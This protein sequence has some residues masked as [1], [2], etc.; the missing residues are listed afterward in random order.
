MSAEE[1]EK[2]PGEGG[3]QPPGLSRDELLKFFDL[4]AELSTT[5][6]DPL[7]HAAPPTPRRADNPDAMVTDDWG[8]RRGR[9]L[10]EEHPE[11]E[12][13]GLD[14][15][16]LADFHAACFDVEPEL[17]PDCA[18]LLKH[19]FLSEL[20]ATPEHHELRVAT[21][22]S[23]TASALAA[24]RYAQAYAELLEQRQVCEQAAE[25][26][27]KAPSTTAEMAGRPVRTDTSSSR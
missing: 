18:R 27:G 19:T 25:R 4:D 20:L 11:L 21:Q 14:A 15:V 6:V 23:E 2:P 3:P 12:E 13:R 17:H 16:D 10:L 8:R 9:D 22:L 1:K 26:T 24:A 7:A 5:E